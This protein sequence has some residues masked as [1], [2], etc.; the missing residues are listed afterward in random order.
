MEY[1]P[2]PCIL[3][4]HASV[5]SWSW[6]PLRPAFKSNFS[7]GVCGDLNR[8]SCALPLLPDIGRRR[9]ERSLFGARSRAWLQAERDNE[10]CFSRAAPPPAQTTFALCANA[11]CLKEETSA[12]WW[13]YPD[14]NISHF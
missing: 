8:R 10:S 13:I 11:R 14:D 3:T 4:K 7:L 5:N 2:S 12:K 6:S 9:E 1:D